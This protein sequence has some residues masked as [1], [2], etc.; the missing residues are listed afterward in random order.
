[1]ESVA[2]SDKLRARLAVK[3]LCLCL[4]IF[5]GRHKV[6]NAAPIAHNA[7]EIR[8]KRIENLVKKAELLSLN[9]PVIVLFPSHSV[10]DE[11]EQT[12]LVK[13]DFAHS[14]I[15]GNSR[16]ADGGNGHNSVVNIALP[17]VKI[18]ICGGNLTAVAYGKKIY[19]V[20]AAVPFNGLNVFIKLGGADFGAHAEITAEIINFRVA[21]IFGNFRGDI[22]F[23]PVLPVG[24]TLHKHGIV[25]VRAV[26]IVSFQLIC[27]RP[28]GVAAHFFKHNGKFFAHNLCNVFGIAERHCAQTYADLR[29][30]CQQAL[31][32]Q[33]HIDAPNMLACFKAVAVIKRGGAVAGHDYN[34]IIRYFALYLSRSGGG[35]GTTG[36]GDCKRKQNSKQFFQNYQ[37][38]LTAIIYIKYTTIFIPKMQINFNFFIHLRRLRIPN[39]Y[40]GQTKPFR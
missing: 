25:G 11:A 32:Y 35:K 26:G 22:L 21:D 20:F 5:I 8:H 12:F 4:L 17:T 30:V 19:L 3:Q 13:R 34:G 15:I 9:Q 14:D 38:F 24:I 36:N 7:E 31:S 2:L 1:M 18:E 6:P 39:K 37:P 40:A 23:V 16:A 29:Y 28:V 10:L 27:A 33:I